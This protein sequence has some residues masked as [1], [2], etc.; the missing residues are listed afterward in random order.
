MEM[1]DVAAVFEVTGG[2]GQAV[3]SAERDATTEHGLVGNRLDDAPAES[4]VE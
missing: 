4:R 2:R 1:L 3:V